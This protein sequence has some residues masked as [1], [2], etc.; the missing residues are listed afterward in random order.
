MN[1]LEDFTNVR[2]SIINGDKQ[3]FLPLRDKFLYVAAVSMQQPQSCDSYIDL[4]AVFTLQ[5]CQRD[6]CIRVTAALA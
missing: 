6:K 4:T 2:D 3:I 5:L 1:S